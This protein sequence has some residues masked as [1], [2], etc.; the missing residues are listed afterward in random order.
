LPSP[1]QADKWFL[2]IP[3]HQADS[4][5]GVMHLSFSQNEKAGPNDLLSSLMSVLDSERVL[6]MEITD[7][8]SHQRSK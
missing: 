8:C 1:D 5:E 7:D 4:S 3:I 2:A 6:A